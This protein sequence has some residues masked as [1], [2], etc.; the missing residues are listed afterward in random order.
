[1]DGR[2]RGAEALIHWQHPQRGTVPPLDFIPLAE[3]TGMIQAIGRWTL[4]TTCQHRARWSGPEDLYVSVNLSAGDFADPQPLELVQTAMSKD[5]IRDPR[6]MAELKAKGIDT[7]KSRRKLVV[8]KGAAR[9]NS[10]PC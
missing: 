9:R 2:L 3:E 4:F 6:K 7:I 5:G 1:M 8:V 10:M